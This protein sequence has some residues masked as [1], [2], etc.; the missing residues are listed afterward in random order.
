[1]IRF[2]IRLAATPAEQAAPPAP[3]SGVA[4][5]PGIIVRPRV[6]E[7]G[8]AEELAPPRTTSSPGHAAFNLAGRHPAGRVTPGRVTAARPATIVRLVG[9]R[10]L[11]T[12]A[13]PGTAIGVKVA[14][15][16]GLLTGRRGPPAPPGGRCW[17]RIIRPVVIG[18]VPGLPARVVSPAAYLF[19]PA[20][21]PRIVPQRARLAATTR[22]AAAARIP[23]GIVRSAR[24]GRRVTTPALAWVRAPS[25]TRGCLSRCGGPGVTGHLA[26][27]AGPSVAAGPLAR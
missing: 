21:A 9:R 6:Q 14:R 17:L 25:L 27:G 3:A 22:I 4:V 5:A 7:V 8:A 13:R 15:P 26:W 23:R 18:P 10:P 16:A 24:G 19:P 1:M 2:C 11:T 12:A 20:P